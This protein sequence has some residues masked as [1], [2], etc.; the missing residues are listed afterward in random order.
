MRVVGQLVGDAVLVTA[1]LRAVHHAAQAADARSH[2]GA[3]LR[4]EPG[5]VRERAEQRA[6]A[7]T[8]RRPQPGAADASENRA[9]GRG[10]PLTLISTQ[11]CSDGCSEA[12]EHQASGQRA[13]SCV[14]CVLRRLVV[15]G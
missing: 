14:V 7:S 4:T 2:A 9:D 10:A 11:G 15:F 3:Q 12:G 1:L 8:A 13:E 5:V 6:Q